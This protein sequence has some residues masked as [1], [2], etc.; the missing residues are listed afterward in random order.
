MPSRKDFAERISTIYKSLSEDL[1]NDHIPSE[2][3]HNSRARLIRNWLAVV[4][5]VALEDF[6]KKRSY[7]TIEEIAMSWITFR[8]IWKDLQEALTTNLVKPLLNQLK[9]IDPSNKI[10]FIQDESEKLASSKWFWSF[11]PSEYSFWYNATNLS[12]GD[13]W[14]ILW[15]FQ[16]NKPWNEMTTLGSRLWLTALDLETSFKNAKENR[17]KAAHDPTSSIPLNDI[18]QFTIDAFSMAISFDFLLSEMVRKMIHDNNFIINWWKIRSWDIKLFFVRFKDRKWKFYKE[19]SIRAIKS[20][21]DYDETFN[22]SQIYLN[23]N[24]WFL[25]IFD[26]NWNIKSWQ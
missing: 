10:A 24:W 11:I 5:F 16:I 9:N 2:I 19:G 6:I 7:E 25:V 1:L 3:E 4:W 20:H 15:N 18:T 13:V 23:R 17:H 26:E 12:E 14:S 8:S 22:Y 21:I